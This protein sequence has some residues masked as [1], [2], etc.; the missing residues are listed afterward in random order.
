[1]QRAIT[2]VSL[3]KLVSW[4]GGFVIVSWADSTLA[5]LRP[6]YEGRF[7]IWYVYCQP[8]RY[9]WC[10]RRVG[11]AAACINAPDPETLVAEIAEQEAATL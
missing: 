10:A 5:A 1:V 11:E 6:M 3:V 9:V 2:G 4:Y 7:D 8:K